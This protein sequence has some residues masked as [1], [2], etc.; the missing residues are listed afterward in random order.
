V[1]LELRD[2]GG[3]VVHTRRGGEERA[4]EV[5]RVVST[6]P[7]PV[8]SS[9]SF[10][11]LD[12]DGLSGPR[13]ELAQVVY[14]PVAVVELGFRREDVAHPL[15]GFGMLVPRVEE[16]ELLGTLF[17]STL[18]E[19][20]APEGHVL[21]ANRLGGTRQP[22]V[23]MREDDELV[24][25]CLAEL[26][27]LLGV[28]GEPTFVHVARWEHAI[29]QYEVGY[30]RVLDE[31]DAWESRHPGLHFVGNFRG[32]IGVHDVIRTASSFARTWSG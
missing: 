13:S 12:T 28:R 26:R 1:G 3:W 14:P 4:H 32:G 27:D 5:D 9:L 10:E 18:F 19:G 11:G 8:F 7:L 23:A 16:R 22:E 25:T 20:R 21:L 31:L 17:T 15:D 30:H 6:L 24:A 29:P 2:D